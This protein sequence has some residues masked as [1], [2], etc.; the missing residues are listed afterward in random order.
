MQ[1]GAVLATFRSIAGDVFR[2][3]LGL[4]QDLSTVFGQDLRG[5][6]TQLGK[7]LEDPIEGITALNRVGVT[8]TETQREMIAEMV[9]VGDIAAAQTV[10][11]DTLE[12]QVGGAGAA[13][14]GG[15]AGAFNMAAD[16]AGA[17][18]EAL[19]E[20]VADELGVSQ[21]LQKIAAGLFLVADAASGKDTPVGWIDD[22][23]SDQLERVLELNREIEEAEAR[24]DRSRLE[25]LTDER[26]AIVAH[27]Q[28]TEQDFE[29]HNQRLQAEA[30]AAEGERRAAIERAAGNAGG[31]LDALEA[32][33]LG[34]ATPAEKIAAINQDLEQTI[35][36]LRS[37]GEQGAPGETVE[38]AIAA[39]EEKA[40][41]QIALVEAGRTG[42]GRGTTDRAQQRLDDY[43]EKLR[44]EETQL[45]LTAEQQ[46][47]YNN[48]RAAGL[49]TSQLLVDASGRLLGVYS[50]EAE[51]IAALTQRILDKTTAEQAAERSEARRGEL[52]DELAM[53]QLERDL[54][55]AG[56]DE[57]ELRLALLERELELKRE[58]I[59]LT[60]EAAQAELNLVRKTI[61]AR[62]ELDDL[63]SLQEDLARAGERAFDRIGGAITEAF[64]T[65]SLEA[66]D[67][68]NIAKAV[69]SELLQE[70]FR[71]AILNP[72]KQAF[73][74]LI[75]GL[76]GAIFG[77]GGGTTGGNL[78]I[79]PDGSAVGSVG[80]GQ[81]HTGGIVG[82]AS[83]TRNVDPAIFAQARRYHRGGL[84]PG[85]VPIIAEE[86]EEVLTEGDPR[87][88]RNGGLGPGK[89]EVH[90]HE[91][92]GTSAKVRSR[93][94]GNGGQ[95]ID[96]LI[97]QLDEALA[98]RA[99]KGDSK[100]G[101]TYERLYGLDRGRG[102][103]R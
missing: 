20:I 42:G 102:V 78:T 65:G 48:L 58:G 60:T 94:D 40:R 70:M 21:A 61:E 56:N 87:H 97:E 50:A 15:L 6:A 9:R 71:I 55:G 36:R 41:R 5:S 7:A 90:V 8:F 62:Q 45:G 75:S 91:A 39:A 33:L 83:L 18:L 81:L 26:D 99:A 35:A 98:Q 4:A 13:E 64:A 43:L 44:F 80:V 95:R 89:V 84:I 88:R 52:Q 68:G 19:G 49:D 67:F 24:G 37:L 32:D 73:G 86:G 92:P 31:I 27:Y 3:T 46:E 54:V 11:L 85:E 53:L 34:L 63:G 82:Q 69:L 12:Q 29:A 1:A 17:L 76:G 2:R 66:L 10:I 38:A 47:V 14:A 28:L 30:D 25:R 79:V 22:G 77:G 59:D 57:R 103:L 23:R 100:M 16:A 72:L 93:D 51:E 101:Q 96:V 74:D